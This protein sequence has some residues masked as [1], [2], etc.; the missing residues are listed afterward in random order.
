MRRTSQDT[1]CAIL[2]AARERFATDGFERATIRA[3]AADA[4]IDPAMVMRYFGSK[5]KLFAAAA[6]FDLGLPGLSALPPETLGRVLA[7]HFTRR[8]EDDEAFM[9]LLR[10]SVTNE[11]AAERLRVISREKLC[12]IVTAVCPDAAQAQRR[13]G[14]LVS[15]VLG[16]ALCRYILRIGPVVDMTRDEVV[17]WLAPA[18]QRCLTGPLDGAWSPESVSPDS[19]AAPMCAPEAVAAG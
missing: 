5:D 3:I 9:V 15:Q 14:L 11:E 7:E 19:V 18:L 6:E 4:G 13:A 17:A 16:F 10:T 2:A 1:K 12:P 8:W